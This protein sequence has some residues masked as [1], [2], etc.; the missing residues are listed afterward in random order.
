MN[1]GVYREYMYIQEEAGEDAKVDREKVEMNGFLRLYDIT[2]P[3]LGNGQEQSFR[4][5]YLFMFV[6]QLNEDQW[7]E[8]PGHDDIP[9]DAKWHA[10]KYEDLKSFKYFP[11]GL[12]FY[13]SKDATSVNGTFDDISIMNRGERTLYAQ[14]RGSVDISCQLD[15][16]NFPFDVQKFKTHIRLTNIDADCLKLK[17]CAVEYYPQVLEKDTF[18]LLEPE[19]DIKKSGLDIV[20]IMTAI[21]DYSHFI[22]QLVVLSFVVMYGAFTFSV[23]ISETEVAIGNLG[24]VILTVIAYKFAIASSLPV[25]TYS[26]LFDKYVDCTVISLFLFGILVA[27]HGFYYQRY[28]LKLDSFWSNVIGCIAYVVLYIAGSLS[29]F[30]YGYYGQRGER[31]KYKAM[32]GYK[33]EMTFRQAQEDSPDLN[34]LVFEYEDIPAYLPGSTSEQPAKRS[35]EAR[36]NRRSKK[37]IHS[38]PER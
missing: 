2:L 4:L 23:G 36:V 21:R 38:G 19:L 34:I 29:W 1:N 33:R 10:L 37:K 28:D 6:W 5:K 8:L 13:N 25:L 3:S 35:A 16:H 12:N 18:Y 22:R 20:V 30:S 14:K 32:L 31:K 17:M 24:T 15:M 11:H 27:Y 7:K 26:T 9:G